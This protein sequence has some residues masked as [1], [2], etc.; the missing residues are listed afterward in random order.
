[1]PDAIEATFKVRYYTEQFAPNHVVTLHTDFDGWDYPIFGVYRR[2]AVASA[3][4][5]TGH[6]LFELDSSAY[7]GVAGATI[8]VSFALD[9]HAMAEQP[10]ELTPFGEY[11]FSA[12]DITFTDPP[13]RFVHGHDNLQTFETPVQQRRFRPNHSESVVYDVIV[14][15]SGM[16]G[17]VLA[18]EL[19][20]QGA[21][22]LLL[23]AGSLLFPTHM[24]NLPGDWEP[25]KDRYFVYHHEVPEGSTFEGGVKINFGGGSLF[26]SGIIQ[27]A[28]KWEFGH[29]WPDTVR[30]YLLDGG[31]YDRA[32]ELMR[33]QLY[34]GPYEQEVLDAL[35]KQF[36]D[37]H[38][39]ALPRARHQ[40][41]LAKLPDG[42]VVLQNVVRESNGLFSTVD[43]LLDS[44]AYAG[45]KG[46][47]NLTINLNHL[48]TK[49]ATDG[50]RAT[51]VMCQDLLA[52]RPREYLG[53]TVVLAAGSLGTTRVALAS[54]LRDPH[55]LIGRGLT[56]H[57]NF[58]IRYEWPIDEAPVALDDHAKLS[59]RFKDAGPDKRPYNVEILVNYQYWDRRVADEDIWNQIV[60]PKDRIGMDV[61]FFFTSPLNENN[62]VTFKPNSNKLSVATERNHVG[63]PYEDEAMQLASELL[64]HLGRGVVPRWSSE[65]RYFGAAQIGHAGGT[66]RMGK[67]DDSVV[68]EYQRMHEYDN[69]YVADLSVFPSILAAKPSLT[70][71]ALSLRLADTIV[72][73]LDARS[74][75]PSARGIR[76]AR[77][78]LGIALS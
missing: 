4:P 21:K 51:G 31:G 1:M 35:N 43:L 37:F 45:P 6:W 75:D 58:S 17:G 59:M 11:N 30:D 24:Y 23:E 34:R 41:H 2:D 69:L 27:Q 53:K 42:G 28:K 63:K 33:M 46:N 14:V 22:V 68:D 8:H 10:S 40:P 18:D 19:S 12:D 32:L 65:L 48:V 7:Q 15:G 44:M 38:T 20:D 52:N 3:E 47:A 62:R 13:E 49:V 55:G 64:A 61:Q 36:P 78:D 29:H 77:G 25:L 39:E 50:K 16:S 54:E 67:A 76:R 26:W 74:G 72:G 60:Q 66:M 5:R 71:T 56:D 57:S 9:G 73:R 70:L